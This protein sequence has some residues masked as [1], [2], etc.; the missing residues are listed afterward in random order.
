[1]SFLFFLFLLLLLL[2]AGAQEESE[3]RCTL[4]IPEGTDG[5]RGA[6]RQVGRRARIAVQACGAG[7]HRRLI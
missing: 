7:M 2:L 1:L 5:T 6:E 4:G 3:Q